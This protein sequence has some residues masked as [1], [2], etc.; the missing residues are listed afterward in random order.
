MTINAISPPNSTRQR[1]AWR[2]GFGSRRMVR[3]AKQLGKHKYCQGDIKPDH[4]H[5][6][7]ETALG[8]F[9]GLLEL[10]DCGVGI[11]EGG[12]N[13]CNGP[14]SKQPGTAIKACFGTTLIATDRYGET[15]LSATGT[16]LF[17]TGPQSNGLARIN[18]NYTQGKE[19]EGFINVR[20]SP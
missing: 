2:A 1:V 5:E 13:S 7:P 16:G 8:P 12:H 10:L 15:T 17:A 3:L 9:F 11:K 20:A 14:Q 4:P 19:N 18:C 6:A